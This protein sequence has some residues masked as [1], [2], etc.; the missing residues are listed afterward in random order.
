MTLKTNLPPASNG[1]NRRA[2]T[3]VQ[4]LSQHSEPVFDWYQATFP[5]Q[6]A[7]DVLDAVRSFM[8]LDDEKHHNYGGSGY[9]QHYELMKDESVV[10][11][12]YFDGNDPH[13]KTTG[14]RAP[15]GARFCRTIFPKHR[16]SR[17]D[18]AY[19]WRG[20]GA[21]ATLYPICRDLAMEQD[22]KGVTYQ[23]LRAKDGH[24]FRMGGDNSNVTANLYEKGFE[25]LVKRGELAEGDENWVRFEVRVRPKKQA[26]SDFAHYT[27]TQM[28]G[29][30]KWSMQLAQRLAIEGLERVQVDPRTETDWQ[31]THGWMIA[32]YGTH[33]LDGAQ[34][35]H[36]RAGS[37]DDVHPLDLM[38][39]QLKAELMMHA[40]ETGH[41]LGG[42]MYFNR[43]TGEIL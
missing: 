32:Q 25:Q 29:A 19:D 38:M 17:A 40:K 5:G 28:V 6:Q 8:K 26:K 27:P 20:E 16:V 4:T 42:R 41:E 10:G 22:I 36:K 33:L 1:L 18:V 24:T 9:R 35:L 2:A 7:G 30:A 11:R 12:L 34:Y 3:N 21:W 13:L 23:P 37:P 31:R 14:L 43:E 15:E 39:D